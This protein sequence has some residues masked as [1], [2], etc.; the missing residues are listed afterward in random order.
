MHSSKGEKLKKRN[1]ANVYGTGSYGFKKKKHNF[2]K[3][4]KNMKFER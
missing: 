4:Q 1:G 2:N 3:S